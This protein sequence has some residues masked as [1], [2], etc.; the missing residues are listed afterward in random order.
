MIGGHHDSL[1]GG[2]EVGLLRTRWVQARDAFSD[3]N[4]HLPLS[5]FSMRQVAR[6]AAM[7]VLSEVAQLSEVA[8]PEIG[9]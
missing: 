5:G 8:G 7:F 2:H 6:R 1:Q 9:E 4:V 3:G